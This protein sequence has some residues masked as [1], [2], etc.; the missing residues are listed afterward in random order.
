MAEPNAENAVHFLNPFFSSLPCK[1]IRNDRHRSFTRNH[2]SKVHKVRNPFGG[3][4]LL[5]ELR[6]RDRESYDSQSLLETLP[7]HVRV[8]HKRV[9]VLVFDWPMAMTTAVCLA[10]RSK[11]GKSKYVYNNTIKYQCQEIGLVLVVLPYRLFRSTCRVGPVLAPRIRKT[12]KV[13]KCRSRTPPKS[14]PAVTA[15]ICR[16][17]VLALLIFVSSLH[18][19]V[20]TVV[21][22]QC[23]VQQH[24]TPSRRLR[25]LKDGHGLGPD[26]YCRCLPTWTHRDPRPQSAVPVPRC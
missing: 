8:L 24:S 26:A 6:T 18:C 2:Q 7:H 13:S 19:G 5:M 15:L 3:C 21:V 11:V 25:K 12:F 16:A 9:S 14:S 4:V 17:T 10:S 20:C 22:H 1:G 23:S